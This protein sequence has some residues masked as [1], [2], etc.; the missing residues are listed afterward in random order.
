MLSDLNNLGLQNILTA[1]IDG[2]RSFPKVIKTIFPNTKLQ[3]YI[4]H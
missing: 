4:I 1:F 2:L 3:L